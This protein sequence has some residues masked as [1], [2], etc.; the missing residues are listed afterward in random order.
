MIRVQLIA[1][2]FEIPFVQEIL[3]TVMKLENMPK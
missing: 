3:P 1:A 2:D